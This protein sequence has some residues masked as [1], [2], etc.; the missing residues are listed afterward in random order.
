MV[1]LKSP[2]PGGGDSKNNPKSPPPDFE[3]SLQPTEIKELRA[4]KN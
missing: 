1:P 3:L 4:R 2:L